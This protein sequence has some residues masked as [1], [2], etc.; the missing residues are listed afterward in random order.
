MDIAHLIAED[1]IKKAISEGEFKNL[2]GLGKPLE[3]EDLSSIPESMRM[4]Y[5]MM[6]NAGMLKSEEDKIRKEL[7]NIEDLMANCD[8]ENEKARL[9]TQLNEKLLQ[10]G[11]VMEKRESSHS[12]AFRQYGDKV[13]SRIGGNGDL[14][15][16]HPKK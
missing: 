8:D 15:R 1:K 11:K 7:I 14:S 6:K 13:Y 5:K 12:K 3:L 10:F 4:A 2:S 9:S 16:S